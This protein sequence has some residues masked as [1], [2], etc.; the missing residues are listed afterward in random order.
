MVF[1]GGGKMPRKDGA[2]YAGAA[3]LGCGEAS[4]GDI[5]SL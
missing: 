2:K 1:E 5:S 4:G 3:R